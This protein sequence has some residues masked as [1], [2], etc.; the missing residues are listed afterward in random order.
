MDWLQVGK[1]TGALAL[2]DVTVVAAPRLCRH[3]PSPSDLGINKFCVNA[4]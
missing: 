1:T 2:G 4:Y 3:L